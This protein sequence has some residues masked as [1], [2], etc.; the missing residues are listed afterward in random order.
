MRIIHCLAAIAGLAAAALPDPVLQAAQIPLPGSAI[1]QF[2]D[3]L[4]SLAIADGTQPVTL[5]MCEFKAN[6]LPTGT[7]TQGV[8][9]C[10]ARPRP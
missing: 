6:V 7:F 3:P 9:P 4:P 5:T 10:S 1:P 2:V 8:A